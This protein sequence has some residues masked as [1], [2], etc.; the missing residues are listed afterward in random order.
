MSGSRTEKQKNHLYAY[1]CIAGN[2]I[3]SPPFAS[4]LPL[5]MSKAKEY[6]RN[7]HLRIALRGNRSGIVYKVVPPVPVARTRTSYEPSESSPGRLTL[8]DVVLVVVFS[9][10]DSPSLLHSTSNVWKLFLCSSVRTGRLIFTVLVPRPVV[11]SSTT[12]PRIQSGHTPGTVA[13]LQGQWT[14]KRKE[15]SD[16]N[17]NMHNLLNMYSRKADKE[18]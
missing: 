1:H 7:F 12:R 2:E 3:A 15:L 5:P 13:S 11:V 9:Q 10:L 14:K 6:Q 4:F 18:I 8:D 16:G 17:S